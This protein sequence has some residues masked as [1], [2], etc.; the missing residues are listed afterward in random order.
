MRTWLD[1]PHHDPSPLYCASSRPS[2]G[3]EVPVRVRVPHAHRARQVVLRVLRDGEPLVLTARP[4][5]EDA[6]AAWWAADL[7]VLNPVAQYRFLL[8]GADGSYSWLNGSGRHAWDVTDAHDFRLLADAAPA[9]GWVEDAV[10]YQVFPD[11]FARSDGAGPVTTEGAPAWAV[12]MEWDGEVAYHGPLASSQ[13]F[14]GDLAGIEQHLDH[15]TSLGSNVLYLT[16]FFEGRSNH[17]YDAISFDRV[18]PL[19]GGD[20]ALAHL[21]DAARARGLRVVGDLTTNHTGDA[22]EWF[23]AAQADPAAAEASFYRFLEHPRRY[24]SWL[25]VPSLPKLD[26]ADAELRRRFYQGPESVVARWLRGPVALDGWRID[27]ANMTGRLG[28]ADLAHDVARAIRA[29]VAEQNPQ[30]W[31]LAEHGHDASGDLTAGG[32]QGTMNYSG[33]TRPVWTWLNQPGHG[34]TWLGMPM[35]VPSLPGTALVETMRTFAASSP[36]SAWTRSVNQLDSHDTARFR[37]VVGGASPQ[38]RA[39]HLVGLALQATLPGVP[40]IFAG[41]ELG[42]TGLTGEHSRTPMPWRHR[43]RWD[44]ATLAAYRFWLS[45]RRDHVAL[46]RG[47]L[48]WVQAGAESVTFLREHPDERLLVHV[49]RGEHDPVVLPAAGLGLS[50]SDRLETLAGTDPGCEDEHSVTMPRGVFAAHVYRL[51]HP[52]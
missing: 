24:V 46:R 12:P 20:E 13:W 47:G 4:D 31:L 15:I 18:D 51:P 29:T 1:E 28:S 5:G 11:R 34:I 9:P 21:A 44:G 30:A 49:T 40:Q 10:V 32:W 48:R 2:L 43:E 38:A 16:P 42:L 3:D 41:D 7:P 6:H 52:L 14:G 50:R 36:W 37:S 39:R 19:L 17:R 23:L 27:V 8:D 26:H 25:D 33:F 35:E 45:L 22:H